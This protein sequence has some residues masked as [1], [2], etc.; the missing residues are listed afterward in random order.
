MRVEV[1][2]AF[3][4]KLWDLVG[5]KHLASDLADVVD[6]ALDMVKRP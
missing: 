6:D 3:Y 4:C 5:A 1:T 2:F